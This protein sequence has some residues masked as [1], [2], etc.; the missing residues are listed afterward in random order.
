IMNADMLA[1]D[2]DLVLTTNPVSQMLQ[3]ESQEI[4]MMLDTATDEEFDLVYMHSQVTAHQRV[5][6][7]LSDQ[8]LTQ[9]DNSELD[10][11]LMQMQTSVEEH[12]ESAE[13]IVEE[14]E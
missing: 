2:E 9:A 8:L 3:D 14:L 1:D 4:I 7:V 12:L 10:S 5:L 11:Y 13:A 6:E